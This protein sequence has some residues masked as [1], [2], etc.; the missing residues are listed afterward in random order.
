YRCHALY[1]AKGGNLKGMI[2][3]LFGKAT[4]CARG[5]AGSMH[6]ID[7]S[8][9][10]MGASAVVG[11]TIPQS[12]G[13]AL[14]LKARKKDSVVASFFGD[15][16][17][18]EGVFHESMNFAALKGVPAV[19]ICENNGYAIHSPRRARQSFDDICGLVRSYG[20]P[21]ERFEKLDVFAI[22]ARVKEAV[23]A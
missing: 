11:T 21:A 10:V 7:T 23:E 22:H 18:E 17:P 13:Y 12:V 6:L 2:A 15:G 8:A 5:K 16:A 9:G 20:I 4:G 3:E 19:F 14:A 1:L